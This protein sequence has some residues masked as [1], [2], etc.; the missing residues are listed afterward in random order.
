MGHQISSS[1]QNGNS[2]KTRKIVKGKIISIKLSDKRF[3]EIKSGRHFEFN[4]VTIPVKAR[5]K[6]KIGDIIHASNSA[7]KSKPLEFMSADN[8]PGYKE[9]QVDVLVFAL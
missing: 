1:G 8:L 4:K 7:G 3:D 5:D 6:L 9:E 2:K